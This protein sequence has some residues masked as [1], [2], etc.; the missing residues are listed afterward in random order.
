M[1]EAGKR[2]WV[3]PHWFRDN[4]YFRIGWDWLKGAPMNRWRLIRNVVFRSHRDPESAMASHK[5]Y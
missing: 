1:V 2:R 5:Q 4:S 3:D